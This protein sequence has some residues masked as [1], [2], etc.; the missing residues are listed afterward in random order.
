MYFMGGSFLG[1]SPAWL[2]FRLRNFVSFLE[3]HFREPNAPQRRAS[4]RKAS[5]RVRQLLRAAASRW[6]T[7]T[8][9]N[10]SLP[11]Q[12]PSRQSPRRPL[13]R[14]SAGPALLRSALSPRRS[15]TRK[16]RLWAAGSGSRERD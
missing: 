3:C 9:E 15:P 5:A 7:R 10:L 11:R 8:A 6:Q 1:T 4:A 16:T 13:L 2:I 14:A 12:T